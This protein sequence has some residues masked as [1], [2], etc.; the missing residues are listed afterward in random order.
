MTNAFATLQVSQYTRKRSVKH[1]TKRSLIDK[2]VYPQLLL[3]TLKMALDHE[4]EFSQHNATAELPASFDEVRSCQN[5]P[6]STAQ[7]AL[8]FRQC[9]IRLARGGLA[10]V[11]AAALKL[12]GILGQ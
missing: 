1:C 11:V 3:T 8:P 5:R 4:N 10:C 6:R 12:E 7:F 2:C 9:A